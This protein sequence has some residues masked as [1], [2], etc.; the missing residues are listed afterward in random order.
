MLLRKAEKVNLFII[1]INWN[2]TQILWDT[3]K[4]YGTVFQNGTV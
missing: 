4:Y 1:F 2:I 3:G